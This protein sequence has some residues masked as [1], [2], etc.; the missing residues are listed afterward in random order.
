M[1]YFHVA[2]AYW[3]VWFLGGHLL[4][5]NMCS[6]SAA[7]SILELM[8]LNF[9][10]I[11]LLFLIPY[12]FWVSH[13]ILHTVPPPVNRGPCPLQAVVLYGANKQFNT[14]RAPVKCC[15]YIC[16]VWGDRFPSFNMTPQ[17]MR[18]LCNICLGGHVA[19]ILWVQLEQE[20]R[21]G[22]CNYKLMYEILKR[23]YLKNN[24]CLRGNLELCDCMFG[25]GFELWHTTSLR[26]LGGLISTFPSSCDFATWK[27]T[28]SLIHPIPPVQF[29]T[30]SSSG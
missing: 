29:R 28:Q 16:E 21:W 7:C 2:K 24:S 13:R 5:G 25:R 1:A 27:Q 8:H 26:W 18:S 9:S 17:L 11:L 23:L 12:Y 4:C 3:P 19:E 15:L 30:A 14:P 10:R 20:G 22:W 6:L